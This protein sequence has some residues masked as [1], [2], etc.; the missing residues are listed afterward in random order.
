MLI[1]K[2]STVVMEFRVTT[3]YNEVGLIQGIFTKFRKLADKA[4]F[5][6]DFTPDE[7]DMIRTIEEY[8]NRT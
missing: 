6:K 7:I 8:L 4:G 3:D 5:K 1:D 2:Q